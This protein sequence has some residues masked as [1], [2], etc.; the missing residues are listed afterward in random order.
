MFKKGVVLLVCQ[1]SK[2]S[3]DITSASCDCG[4]VDE[5]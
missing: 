5:Y 2:L 3:H 1:A 4:E